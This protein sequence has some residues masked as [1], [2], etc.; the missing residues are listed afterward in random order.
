MLARAMALGYTIEP[1]VDLPALEGRIVRLHTPRQLGT[2]EALADLAH[3]FPQ[4]DFVANLVYRHYETAEAASGGWTAKAT[5]PAS[6]APCERDRCFGHT[7]I[8][9]KERL[10][11]CATGL[12]IGVIDTAVDL[13]H[14]AF[15]HHRPVVRDFAP[16]ATERSM[17]HGTAVVSLLAG[18]PSGATPGLV[19]D[20]AIFAANVFY[21]EAD[22]GLTADTMSIVAAL[23]WLASQGVR[24]VNMSYAGPADPLVEAAIEDMRRLGTVFVAAAGNNGPNAE[25]VFPAAYPGVIAVTAVS[26]D[27]SGYRHANRG[28]YIDVAAPGVGIWTALPG[29]MAG[30]QTGTSFAAPYVTAILAVDARLI[31]VG[32]PKADLLAR[33]EIRDLGKPGQD[34]VY[35]RG[36]LLAPQSCEAPGMVA[37]P[38]GWSPMRSMFGASLADEGATLGGIGFGFVKPARR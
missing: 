29:G 37:L 2:G 38:G 28:S 34:P 22:G 31:G 35:G 12:R 6:G 16:A 14:S 11:A 17:D 19:P 21:R 1:V 7:V 33:I 23:D 15:R 32:E 18:D 9:W 20:A 4:G 13:S 25:P 30:Y 24:I 8:H 27:L 26:S 10:A 3:R 5:A 36:L